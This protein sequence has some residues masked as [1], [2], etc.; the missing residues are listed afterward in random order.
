MKLLGFILVVIYG[1]FLIQCSDGQRSK[2]E[3]GQTT[4]LNE[5]VHQ[6]L[7]MSSKRSLMRF[8]GNKFRDFVKMTP[9][10]YSVVVMFTAMAPQRQCSICRHA[11]DEFHILAN[12]FRY[13]HMASSRLFFAMVDFDEGSDI[14]QMMRLNTAPVFIH[15]PPK[16]K[17]KTA[18]T[19]DIQRVGFSADAIAKW[20]SERTDVA[21]RI[22][23]PPN[24]SGTMACVLLIVLVATFLYVRRNNLDFLYNKTGWGLLA[25]LFCFTMVS[26]QMW[27]HIR[28]PP[29][30]HKTPS[31][32]VAYIHGSSQGQFVLETYIVFFLN[33]AVT[34]GMIL[35]TEGAANRG[36][37][38]KRRIVVILGLAL[39]VTFFSLILSI[40]RGKAHGYPYSFLFK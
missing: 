34:L 14:F 20:I 17:P 37:V 24:Y 32:G 1:A 11:H 39:F 28:G 33:A 30:I 29:F 19:L 23:R 21:I 18:D 13:A 38:K 31:G 36:D 35:V 40:F 12:S 25:L 16:G 26:G 15:F 4:S 9:R 2:K 27:N 22:F 3:G 6:L 10:N 5:R 8:N 7:E